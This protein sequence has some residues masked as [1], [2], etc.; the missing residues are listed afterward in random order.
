M[1]LIRSF[2]TPFLF[3]THNIY[4]RK[5]IALNK[6]RAFKSI[7]I[8]YRNLVETSFRN[9][10]R[11]TIHMYSIHNKENFFYSILRIIYNLQNKN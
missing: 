8:T 11:Y 9:I 4:F 3:Q 1:R 2:E 10:C 6:Y 5:I 7:F